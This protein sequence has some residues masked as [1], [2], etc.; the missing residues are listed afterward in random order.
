M[1]KKNEK[2]RERCAL[3]SKITEYTKNTPISERFGYIEG[4][5]QFEHNKAAYE[6]AI[7]M[8][9]ETGKATVIHP[10][11][12][13]KSFIG[14]KLCED[15]SDKTVCWLSPSSYIFRT[16]IENLQKTGVTVP[17]N[18]KFYTYQKLTLLSDE[19]I[20][21]IQ[22]DIFLYDE[23]HRLG[24]QVWQLAVNKLIARYPNVPMLGLSA[25][26]V[27]YLDNQRDMAEELF[28][29]NIASEMTLGEAIVRGI[30]KAPLYISTVFS[31][32]KD[33]EKYTRMAK[34]PKFKAVRDTAEKYLE[35]Q[36]R[37]I[38]KADGLDVI[39]EKYMPDK[40]GKYVVFC[41]NKE[42]LDEMFS[43]V[44][45]WFSKVDKNPKVYKV[46]SDNPESSGEFAD[47]KAD[48]SEN[49]KLLFCID[50]LNEGV[51]LDD[52]DGVI[53]FRPTVSPTVY[54]QQI[55]RALTAGKSGTPVIFDI[56]NNFQN[57]YSMGAIEQEMACAISYY[58]SLGESEKITV[59]KFEIIGIVKD[60]VELFDKL[61]ETFTAGWNEMY[62]C[63]CEYKSV[64]GNI[65][66]PRR[67]KTE[68]GLSLGNW[69]DTQRGVR[70]GKINGILTE[71]RIK[72]LDE[73]GMRWESMSDMSWDKNYAA[74]V[75]YAK[76]YGDLNPKAVYVTE[77]GIRLGSW[78]SNVRT[79]RKCGI[80]RNYL[81]EERIEELDKIGMVWDTPNYFFEK[82]Y[83]ALLEYFHTYG[84]L[85]VPADYVS[86]DGIKLGRCIGNLRRAKRNGT[87]SEIQ[88]QRLNE[89]GMPWDDK[90]TRK[91]ENGFEHAKAYF[92]Q[93]GNLDVPT[94]FV[95][96]DGFKLGEWIANQRDKSG[97]KVIE[98]R[99]KKLDSISMIWK[100]ADPWEVR[101]ALAKKYFEE[102]GNLDMPAVYNADG[103]C[104]SKWLNEQKHIYY[105]RRKGKSL[106]DEQIKRLESIGMQWRDRKEIIWLSRYELLKK[107]VDEYG[108]ADV[109]T[110]YV[111]DGFK[112]GMWRQRQSNFY[113]KGMLTSEQIELLRKIG[114]C[115]DTLT[116]DE[117]WDRNYN[118]A[119]KWYSENGN[120]NVP[121]DYMTDD[122]IKLYSWLGNQKTRYTDGKL[123]SS[124]IDRLRLIG[125]EFE[126]KSSA[127]W[128]NAY[129]YAEEYYKANLNLDVPSKYKLDNGFDLG[130]WVARQRRNKSKLSDEQVKALDSIGMVWSAPAEKQWER[131]F[132]HLVQYK[133]KYG[134]A[135]PG[136][137]YRAEDGYTLGRWFSRQ[138]KNYID[139]E[140]NKEQIEKLTQIGVE[141]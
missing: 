99:R 18:I 4:C 69:L 112:L 44:S 43:H 17:Q 123:T 124:Q 83:A 57:L 119:L 134:T 75:E 94:M 73:L 2:E 138:K 58:N 27:R 60:C 62:R 41:A 118:A 128:K 111:I 103:M 91:W 122:G 114:M 120:L 51:H 98:E 116:F 109:P 29:G 6:S 36:W 135:K 14:F 132:E 31:Y 45:E 70:S 88:I 25:T 47:F 68:S 87:L 26:N 95:C 133:N 48:K 127:A 55:G 106:T 105:G 11:G 30:L 67:Y 131:G 46:Y 50:M 89:V 65:D 136:A 56:I 85:D 74:A 140:L 9:A 107:Y 15:N 66:V 76:K 137:D 35:E 86:P 37:T 39:F 3:C 110:D 104:I 63:A 78:I 90:F 126:N 24:A 80:Q 82:N 81:T 125:F 7:A 71:E 5:G 16:Q 129:R 42:H 139:G 130:D 97:T 101:F 10:T 113:K 33:L 1:P 53:L 79:Y 19:E 12:T 108:T 59:D 117:I 64:Y 96:E 54:K 38:E 32:Q 20:D 77:D 72:K 52:I 115:L 13:G 102:H 92:V 8:L 93:N 141:L 121:Q 100:K 21:A 49:L 40:H 61:N 28:D 22:P 23:Y 34:M 84:D